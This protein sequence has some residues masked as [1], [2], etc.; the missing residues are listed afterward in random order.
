MKRMLDRPIP[1]GR[2]AARAA[3]TL[4][5]VLT[6]GCASAPQEV[7]DDRE[8]RRLIHEKEFL[9]FR[10]QCR[11]SGGRVYIEGSSNVGRKGIPTRGAHYF[12]S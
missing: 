1:P 3:L 10:Q 5:A 11:R 9:A 7:R 2:R 12:C 8:Y 4:L 6:A